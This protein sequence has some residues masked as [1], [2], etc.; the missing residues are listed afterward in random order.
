[1][2]SLLCVLLN[3]GEPA[4]AAATVTAGFVTAITV[5]SGGSGY[6]S[7][8]AV[9][10]TGGGG[11]GATAK[12]VLVE[13]KVSLIVVLTAGTGYLFSLIIFNDRKPDFPQAQFHP[14]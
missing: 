1:M 14:S 13:G 8:P 11:S 6:T 4:T 7:E 9:A 5:T 3:A 2:L 12:A 10:I